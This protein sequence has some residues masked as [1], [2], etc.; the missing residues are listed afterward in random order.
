MNGTYVAPTYNGNGA[1]GSGSALII[2]STKGYQ[3]PMTVKVIGGTITSISGYAVEE[4]S[5]AKTEAEKICYS[6]TTISS[7]TVLSGKLGRVY[8]ENGTVTIVA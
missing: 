6:T 1:D 7:T 3:T 2:D 4:V 5:N 8:S